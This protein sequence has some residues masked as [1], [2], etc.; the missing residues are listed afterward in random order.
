VLAERYLG[1][2]SDSPDVY[3]HHSLLEEP[4]PD[5]LLVLEADAPLQVEL[6]F[7]RHHLTPSE[8]P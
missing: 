1:R 3:A 5:G 7:I 2:R 6:E 8:S 4:L